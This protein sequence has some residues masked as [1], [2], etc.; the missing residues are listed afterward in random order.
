MTLP[1][2]TNSLNSDTKLIDLLQCCRRLQIAL[3]YP[4]AHT[5]A[6][7]VCTRPIHPLAPIN[8]PD[9]ITAK[10]S[11]ADRVVESVRYRTASAVADVSR[12]SVDRQEEVGRGCVS[13]Q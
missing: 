5:L 6:G 10:N 12:R 8:V 9:P 7:D 11:Y 4:P 3:A 1:F 2:M 13:L